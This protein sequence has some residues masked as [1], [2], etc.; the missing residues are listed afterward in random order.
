MVASYHGRSYDLDFLNKKCHIT[1]VGTSM[2]KLSRAAKAIGFEC[3]GVKMGIEQLKEIVQQ[4]PVILHWNKNHFVVIYK[5]PKPMKQGLFYVAD[6]A[7]GF[8][9]YKET[10]FAKNWLTRKNGYCLLI[11]SK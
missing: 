8:V 4:I 10:E 5:A 6:P 3:R 11:E 9:L 1:K 7:K 2:L